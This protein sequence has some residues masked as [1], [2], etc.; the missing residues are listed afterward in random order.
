MDR[1]D[2]ELPEEFLPLA[3]DYVSNL[4]GEIRRSIEFYLTDIKR[5]EGSVTKVI[6][7]GSGYWP[8][9]LPKIL[10]LQLNLPLIDL[11]F[12]HIPNVVCQSSFAPNFPALGIY[13]PVVGSVL[14]GVA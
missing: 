2:F 12:D 4:L 11:R 7:A 3:T 9:N 14:R 1:V 13:A 8:V 10:A 6:L 5:K